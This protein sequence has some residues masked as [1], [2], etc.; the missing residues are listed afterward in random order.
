MRAFHRQVRW[1]FFLASP[2]LERETNSTLLSTAVVESSRR[3]PIVVLLFL[4]IHQ[5]YHSSLEM[6][7]SL[8]LTPNERGAM[9]GW[10]WVRETMNVLGRVP[11]QSGSSC[12]LQLHHRSK[13][14]ENRSWSSSY[15]LDIVLLWS[16]PLLLT[17]SSPIWRQV[18][19]VLCFRPDSRSLLFVP[20]MQ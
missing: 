7:S 20:S 15:S 1:L 5:Y 4:L 17:E 16:G 19:V 18:L 10:G 11:L 3:A 13:K 14:G 2:L 9:R 12:T 6:M 8:F